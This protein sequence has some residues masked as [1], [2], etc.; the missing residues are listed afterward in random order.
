MAVGAATF[1]MHEDPVASSAAQE[2]SQQEGGTRIFFG[3]R[4][5]VAANHNF[6]DSR[7]V[8]TIISIAFAGI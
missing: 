8:G 2:P 6:P 7:P 4:H 3:S 5:A 1:L